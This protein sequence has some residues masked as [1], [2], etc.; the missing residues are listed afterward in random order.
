MELNKKIAIHIIRVESPNKFWF[1][2]KENDEKISADIETYMMSH[3]SP[4][5]DCH[6][7]P[8]LNEMVIVKLKKRFEIA[9]IREIDTTSDTIFC[10][11]ASG[12][13]RN[14][15]HHDISPAPNRLAKEANDTILLGSIAGLVPAK[16]VSRNYEKYKH[17]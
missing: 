5:V 7:V 6:F 10:L 14:I 8:Q 3:L 15:K 2:T 9:Q 4:Q 17:F 12:K 11:F 13:F 16:M 1:R